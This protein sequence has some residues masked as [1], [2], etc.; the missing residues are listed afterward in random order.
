[1][2]QLE[3]CLADMKL[4]NNDTTAILAGDMNIQEES[5]LCFPS[6]DTI[7]KTLLYAA[8]FFFPTCLQLYLVCK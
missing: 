6:R 3:K 8:P 7:D 5:E 2:V 4:L 1:M